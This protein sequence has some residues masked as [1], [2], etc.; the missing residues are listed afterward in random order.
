M[1]NHKRVHVH[2]HTYPHSAYSHTRT[3]LSIKT[4]RRPRISEYHRVGRTNSFHRTNNYKWNPIAN[5]NT[6]ANSNKLNSPDQK[7]NNHT[8]VGFLEMQIYIPTI[9]LSLYSNVWNGKAFNLNR[10]IIWNEIFDDAR[11]RWLNDWTQT[12]KP[13]EN[14]SNIII[15]QLLSFLT[16]EG[17]L[18][19]GPIL[20]FAKWKRNVP[21]YDRSIGR[22][23]TQSQKS[24]FEI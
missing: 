17:E 2:V 13:T 23:A 12:F 6:N 3:L 19:C 16:L 5:G 8:S 4:I 24:N 22:T 1:I 9:F 14:Y 21:L 11:Q 7:V 10:M 15:I 20:I 18:L